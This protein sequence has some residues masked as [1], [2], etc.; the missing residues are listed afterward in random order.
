MTLL[1]VLLIP[2]GVPGF[3]PTILLGA[4]NFLQLPDRLARVRSRPQFLRLL[5]AELKIAGT[6]QKKPVIS[7]SV[8]CLHICTVI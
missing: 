6:L 3:Y 8:V 2:L 4:G 5:R 7:G 1:Y